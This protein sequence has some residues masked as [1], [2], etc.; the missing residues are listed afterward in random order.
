MVEAKLTNQQP[1]SSYQNAVVLDAAKALLT[2]SGFAPN[3]VD[4]ALEAI[5]VAKEQS[6]AKDDDKYKFFLDR[7]IIYEDRDA[8]IFKRKR[9]NKKSAIWYFRI[10]DYKRNKPLVKSLKTRDKIQALASARVLY[11]EIKGKIERGERLKQ[12]TTPEL[13]ELWL[14]K[15]EK[16]ITPV[17]H[18]GITQGTFKLKEGFAKNWLLYIE[19]L[20][21]SKTSIDRL[22]PEVG[23]DFGSWLKA[24]PKQT[25]LRTGSRSN[26]QINNNISFVIRMYHRFAIREKYVSADL[27]PQFDRVKYEISEAF[28]RDIFSNLEQYDKYITYLK[29]NYVTKKHNPDL[30]ASKKG[31]K[32]LEVRK[33]FT[34]FI[35]ILS[36]AGFRT[37]E[38]L[39]IKFKEIYASP[40]FSEE[41]KKENVVMVVRR[42]NAKTGKRRSVVAPVKKRIDRIVAA[43]KRLGITHEPE[44]FLFINPLSSTRNQYG[45]MIMYQRLKKTLVASGVQEELDKEDKSIS[46][47]SFRHFYAYLRLINRVPIHLLAANMGTSVQKIESTYGHVNTELHTEVLTAGQG[48]IKRTGTSLQTLPTL[49]E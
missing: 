37:K 29:R 34:E 4:V 38:L 45:R 46:P 33:I 40:S 30:C 31:L 19:D 49:D 17:P 11:I 48:I 22:K 25:A 35:L 18:E 6:P 32:E 5:S 24:K 26:E 9:G 23:R 16:Q 15:L 28:K 13:V 8:F 42:E 2:A 14:N 3:D 44:D 41:E 1:P 43:Y 10:Y 36:N 39:G 20:G 12:I 47:Y 7:T 27:I 21:L